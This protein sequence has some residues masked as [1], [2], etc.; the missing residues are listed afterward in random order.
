[1]V[2]D[3]FVQ[4]DINFSNQSTTF[5]QAFGDYFSPRSKKGGF[6]KFVASFIPLLEVVFETKNRSIVDG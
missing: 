3:K 2:G 5:D 6:Y 1:M 4:D